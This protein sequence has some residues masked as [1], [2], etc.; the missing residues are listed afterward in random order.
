MAAPSPPVASAGKHAGARR[1]RP[2][3]GT[4]RIR[5]RDRRQE[6]AQPGVAVAAK[7]GQ[8]QEFGE[9]HPVP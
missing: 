4:V 6:P 5:R 8:G 1:E 2:A 9:R 7:L 3:L